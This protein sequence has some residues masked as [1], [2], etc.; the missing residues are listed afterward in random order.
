MESRGV[1]AVK[2]SSVFSCWLG[3]PG[4]QS[5]NEPSGDSSPVL[6]RRAERSRSCRRV[7]AGSGEL[8]LVI[9]Q[10]NLWWKPASE[11][12]SCHRHL[13]TIN[14]LNAAVPWAI[15]PHGARARVCLLGSWVVVVAGILQTQAKR[16]FL[17]EITCICSRGLDKTSIGWITP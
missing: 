5:L 11:G 6:L 13:K 7:W 15:S 3:E 12:L 8:K 2:V 16:F 14:Q 9:S 17:L 10:N 4:C 1:P